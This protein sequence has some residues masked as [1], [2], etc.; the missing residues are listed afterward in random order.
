[1]RTWRAHVRKMGEEERERVELRAPERVLL[2][3]SRVRALLAV[4]RPQMPIARMRVRVGAPL[5][6][7]LCSS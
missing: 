6:V 4:A 7:A 5:E 1:M 3:R 2:F